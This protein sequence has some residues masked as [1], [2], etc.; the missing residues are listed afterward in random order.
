M[1]LQLLMTGNEILSGDTLD[2]NSA[3]IAQEL[4][5][6]GLEVTRVITV[7]D[8]VEQLINEIT[9][10]SQQADLLIINGG[11]GPTVDD[12][13]AEALAR[14]CGVTLDW[15]TAALEHVQTWCQHR[16]IKLNPQ[17]KKQAFLPDGCDIIANKTGSA[18]GFKM[19][20]NQCQ[21]YCTPGVPSELKYMLQDEI[22]PTISQLLGQKTN[23]KIIRL[24]VFGLGEANL[25]QLINQHFPSWPAEIELGFR[26]SMPTIELKLT[27]RS[28]RGHE[29]QPIWQNKLIDV[30]GHHF[31]ECIQ[32]TPRSL[33]EIVI[34]HLKEKNATL[35]TAES[36]TGGLIASQI[37]RISGSSQVFEAGFVT[38]SNK[39]KAS[40]IDVCE[41]ALEKHGAVS[42]TVVRQM[43]QGALTKAN[44]N[45]AIAVSGIAGPSG[46][47]PEKP[48]G[49]VW[50]AW[51]S[52]DDLKSHCFFIKRERKTF[53][54]YISAI[55]LD[56]I[57]RDLIG[58]S[59]TPA[60]IR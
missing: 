44:A 56:L 38:Y 30:L 36:C 20:L 58:S 34:E 31:I 14:A 15:H 29:L 45:Y 49:T 39:V 54:Q 3:F 43:A 19:E 9:T 12:L 51:G 6:I 22:K 1:Q 37:T 35:T 26:A 33:A 60:Y 55:A 10:I 18:V 47:S 4:K 59:E 41:Q 23:T 32:T 40:V 57:R 8:Q 17:N 28:Q 50:V 24:M 2:T 42:E 13:T 16:N 53:Q 52:L 48:V 5:S 25:Q 7:G 21:I 27:S 46:G 11:L